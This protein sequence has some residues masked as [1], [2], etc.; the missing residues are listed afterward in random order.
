[1]VCGCVRRNGGDCDYF[2][3]GEDAGAGVMEG[4]NIDKIN[5]IDGGNGIILECLV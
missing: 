1:M 3:D 5:W 2:D 4:W